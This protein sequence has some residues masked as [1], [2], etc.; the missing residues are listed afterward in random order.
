MG[1]L[2]IDITITLTWTSMVF[3]LLLYFDD[4]IIN[5]VH[6]YHHSTW[7]SIDIIIHIVLN[8]IIFEIS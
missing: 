2:I 5:I 4:I 8:F 1:D 7:T 6:I 3:D